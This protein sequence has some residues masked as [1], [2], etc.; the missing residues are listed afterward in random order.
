VKAIGSRWTDG[1]AEIDF[2][3]RSYAGGHAGLIVD[4]GS[5]AEWVGV[6]TTAIPR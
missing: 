5:F 1:Q 2:C 3:V 6:G 4:G